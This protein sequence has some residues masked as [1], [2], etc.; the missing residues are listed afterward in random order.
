MMPSLKRLRGTTLP[1]ALAFAATGLAC[2][3]D[4]PVEDGAT[5]GL[6]SDL[7]AARTDPGL[8]IGA[9]VPVG[10]ASSEMSRGA[11]TGSPVPPRPVAP[12]DLSLLG[13]DVGVDDAPI[14]I[15]EFSDF[16]CGY[17]RKFHE[18]IYPILEEEYVATGK[19][20]WKYVPMILGIFGPNAEHA[21]RA[22]ECGGEQDRFESMRDRLFSGQPEW[23]GADDPNALFETYASELGLDVDRFRSC[24]S[25]GWMDQR[26]VAGTELSRQVGVRGTPT[27]VVVGYAPIPGALPLDLFRQVLDTVYADKMRG[28]N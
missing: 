18:E 23:K 25:E 10:G 5:T 2:G 4:L 16:G 8:G 22:G 15:V 9:S 26:I 6:S 20:E 17:C 24:V 19:V 13:Y 21:A 7:L 11:D 12:T 3:G 27:F 1:I 28:G 14:R